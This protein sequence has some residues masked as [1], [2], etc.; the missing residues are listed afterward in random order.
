MAGVVLGPERHRR[1]SDAQKIKIVGE[2]LLP[3]VRVAEVMARYNVSSSLIYTWRK[4]ARLGLFAPMRQGAFAPVAIVEPAM[5]PLSDGAVSIA[6]GEGFTPEPL[7]QAAPHPRTDCHSRETLHGDGTAMIVAL[8][9]GVR[10]M[11]NGGVDEAALGRVLRALSQS[12]VH[13]NAR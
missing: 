13:G 4:Q 3:G 6:A 7:A 10:V 1:W 8:P 9:D 5:T 11:V 2:T 12:P